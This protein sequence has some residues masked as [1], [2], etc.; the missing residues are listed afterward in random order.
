MATQP[1]TCTMEESVKARTL[2]AALKEDRSFSNMLS[3]L[4]EL[5]LKEYWKGFEPIITDPR[6][7]LDANKK[8]GE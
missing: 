6:L 1:V 5:G 3:R 4:V 7:Y 2:Q 8:A